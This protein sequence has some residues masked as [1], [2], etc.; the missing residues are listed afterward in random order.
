MV[1]SFNHLQMDPGTHLLSDAVKQPLLDILRVQRKINCYCNFCTL[2]A[3]AS[4]L[5]HGFSNSLK[6]GLTIPTDIH[7]FDFQC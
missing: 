2:A 6:D 1:C 5:I 3:Y 7:M 4:A